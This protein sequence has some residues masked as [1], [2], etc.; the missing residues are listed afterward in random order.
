MQ[1]CFTLMRQIQLRT[2]S[3]VDVEI[4]AE[5]C[6][7]IRHFHLPMSTALSK[8]TEQRQIP[9]GMRAI[10]R[11]SSEYIGRLPVSSVA[12]SIH[13]ERPAALAAPGKNPRGA[14]G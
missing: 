11:P 14:G 8:G 7:W 12:D 13:N 2:Q 3:H 10:I 9:V 6:K 4:I 5:G 1:Q